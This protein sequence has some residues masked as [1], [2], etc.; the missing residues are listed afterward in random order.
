MDVGRFSKIFLLCVSFPIYFQILSCSTLL[1]FARVSVP[2]QAP[3]PHLHRSFFVTVCNQT[4]IAV[5]AV[6]GDIFSI[7]NSKAFYSNA[8]KRT[9]GSYFRGK[10]KL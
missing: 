10:Y 8:K 7:E 4:L 5:F 3:V 1:Q 2:L 6:I 9:N